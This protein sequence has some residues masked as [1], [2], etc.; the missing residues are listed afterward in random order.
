MV[1]MRDSFLH[2][3]HSARTKHDWISYT[4]YSTGENIATCIDRHI[5]K[6]GQERILQVVIDYTGNECRRTYIHRL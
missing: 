4:H 3:H 2:I 6:S 1:S 5:S